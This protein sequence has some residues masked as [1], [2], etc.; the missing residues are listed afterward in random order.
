MC[1]WYILNTSRT[2]V[3]CSLIKRFSVATERFI[4]IRFAKS[5]GNVDVK[6][7]RNQ[8]RHAYSS[9]FF[10]I[11]SECPRDLSTGGW[12]WIHQHW[13]LTFMTRSP[14]IS[15]CGLRLDD[16][17]VIIAVSRR[18][19]DPD[20]VSPINDWRRTHARCTLSTLLCRQT[21]TSSRTERPRV[22]SAMTSQ[23]A[24]QSNNRLV[25]WG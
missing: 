2:Q 4:A 8:P 12:R 16:D 17:T 7:R 5:F 18:T 22:A 9:F 20:S 15:S 6:V 13:L 10:F 25:W 23:R 24:N 21:M 14:C 1:I 19:M 3:S 11:L